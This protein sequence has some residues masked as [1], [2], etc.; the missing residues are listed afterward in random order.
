MFERFIRLARAKKALRDRCCEDALALAS[1]PL[2][3]G[4]RRA[5]QIRTAAAAH[6]L[7][8]A[9]S[10]LEARELGAARVEAE[11]VRRLSPSPE[12]DALLAKIEAQRGAEQAASDLARRTLAQVRKLL[13]AGEGAAAAALLATVAPAHL[14]FERQQLEKLLHERRRQAEDLGRCAAQALRDGGLAAAIEGLDRAQAIDRDAPS[15]VALRGD[16]FTAA[17]D[18]TAAKVRDALAAGDP[19]VA[20]ELYGAALRRLP[21]LVDAEGLTSA[22]RDLWRAVRGPLLAAP[23]VDAVL[24]LA[25]A[26]VGAGLAGDEALGELCGAVLHAGDRRG[27]GEIAATAAR[28][29]TAAT[30]VGAPGLVAAADHLAAECVAVD[31]RLANVHACIERGELDAARASLLEVLAAE[32]LH[33]PARRELAMV[34]Q[35]LAEI[36]RRLDSAR[37]AAREGRLR[38]ACTTAQTV[39]GPARHAAEAQSISA[40]VRA[41]MALVDRGLDEVRVAL[42]GRLG[43]G[44]EGVRHC[45]RRLEELA[46]VQTDHEEL[47]GVLAAVAA[48]IDALGRCEEAGQ[49]VERRAFDEVV[50]LVQGLLPLCDRLIAKD[51]LVAR[52]CALADRIRVAGDAGVA[53]GQLTVVDRCADVLRDLATIRAE[54]AESAKSLAE[55]AAERRAECDRAIAA[56]K[57]CLA[58][59]DLAEAERFAEVAQEKW[60]DSPGA[61]ALLSQLAD[62]RRQSD[63]LVRVEVMTRERDLLGAQQRLAAMPPTQALLRTRVFDMK[64]N[65]A[66][67]QGLEGSFLLRVDEGGEQLVLRGESVS[68]GNVRQARADVP[69]LA[70]LAGLHATIRRSMSFHGGMVDTIVAQEGEV[71]VGGG[72]VAERALGPGDLVQLGPSFAFRYHRPSGRSLSAALAFQ[73]GFQV[74]GT[75]RLVLMKD[76]GRDGRILIGPGKDVHVRV[77]RATGEVEVFATN[78]GQV[79]VACEAGGTIDGV[80]FRGEHPLAAG[81]VVEAA[82]VGLVLMPWRPSA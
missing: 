34:E 44:V 25:A 80:P 77:A 41:R 17:A 57:D 53:A 9:A 19:M 58:R 32:P 61:R 68:I 14:L 16:V 8:R 64:Q 60:L 27:R 40:D 26:V 76:R 62:L 15:T 7:E 18:Q 72:A 54:F 50:G 28:L 55:R 1:D 39:T 3:A 36:D 47:P 31:R 73:G 38:Q 63:D 52:L 37:A 79:R 30:A 24:P 10:H 2:I 65:L 22:R 75:D 67:A 82:G 13:D 6:L 49:A 66:R 78:T 29:R 4:D 23:S 81:Q 35:G 42:H 12:A 45:L 59:R 20:I 48:E 21:G 46:K 56:A 51:R 69:V 74:A 5:A 71:R 11:L 33:E 70:N 43:A